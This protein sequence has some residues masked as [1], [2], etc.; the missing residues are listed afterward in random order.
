MKIALYGLPCAGKSYLLEKL[1]KSGQTTFPVFT[2][3][4]L[5]LERE[6]KFHSL[7]PTE[8]K[9]VRENLALDLKE[10]E[11]FYLDG[12]YAFG[13]E[14]VFTPEDGNL[15]DVFCYLYLAPDLLEERMK[16]SEK[17]Q[18]YLS[19]D[20]KA[21]QE[22]EIQGLRS[23]CHA[24]EKDF[25]VLDSPKEKNEI[26]SFL[27]FFHAIEEGYSCVSFARRE[28]EKII[29]EKKG[30][31]LVLT[32]GDKT[33]VKE[34]TSSFFFSYK[35]NIFD[36][37]FYTGYQQWMSYQEQKK[38]SAEK[39]DIHSLTFCQEV[40]NQCPPNQTII[41]TSGHSGV[42]E[43]IAQDRGYTV[44]SGEE[45]CADTKYFITAFLQMAGKEVTAFGDSMNEYAMLKQANT[46][47]LVKKQ[48][49]T[50]SRSLQGKNL[51]GI[52]W[53]N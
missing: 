50:I 47:Y 46:G 27:G 26:S 14:I 30:K 48:D 29:K 45:M 20:V 38:F 12:H 2:G 1:K 35:T 23:Y 40:K 8:K 13:E 37:N 24:H 17:N 34:D 22:R 52:L 18:K 42:W 41:L 44:L 7:S 53:L 33:L 49:G 25:Y 3:S 28:A 19:L 36:G 15:F 6:E 10:K 21:W 32:D 51:E 16:V 39:V 9:K 11:N 5:L 43:K 4:H 31:S